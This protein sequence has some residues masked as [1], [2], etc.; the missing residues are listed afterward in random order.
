MTHVWRWRT[1]LPER[2][3]QPCRVLA[4]GRMNSALVEFEGGL[5]H[6]VSRFAVRRVARWSFSHCAAC[7]ENDEGTKG[8][9]PGVGC[10]S[11][12]PGADGCEAVWTPV[13]E[14]RT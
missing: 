6:V 14:A 4:R 3:G 5:Q 12:G 2:F 13:Y 8:H 1:N 9:D 7:A 10:P 11:E